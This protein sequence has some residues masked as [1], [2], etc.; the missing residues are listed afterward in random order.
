MFKIKKEGRV[1]D[2]NP[3]ISRK[4]SEDGGKDGHYPAQWRYG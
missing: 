3:E 4:R 1:G 2:K